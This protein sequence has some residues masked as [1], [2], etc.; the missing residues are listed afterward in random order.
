MKEGDVII[1]NSATSMNNYDHGESCPFCGETMIVST[2]KLGS[3]F[4]CGFD[5]YTT[6]LSN[7]IEIK[8]IYPCRRYLIESLTIIEVQ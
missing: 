2:K 3:H 6:Q 5:G 7:A 4:A 1:L 8:L